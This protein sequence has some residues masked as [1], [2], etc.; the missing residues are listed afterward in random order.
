MAKFDKNKVEPVYSFTPAAIRKMAS[1]DATNLLVKMSG[2]VIQLYATIAYGYNSK[3]EYNLTPNAYPRIMAQP[4]FIQRRPM[5]R[6]ND[7]ELF[8][9]IGDSKWDNFNFCM[10][11]WLYGVDDSLTNNDML[12]LT[13]GRYVDILDSRFVEIT[14]IESERYISDY[15]KIYLSELSRKKID[16][17][18]KRFWR[19]SPYLDY[20]N[21]PGKNFAFSGDI[22]TRQY[23]GVLCFEDD[24]P[25]T[26]WVKLD[27]INVYDDDEQ[28]WRDNPYVPKSDYTSVPEDDDLDNESDATKDSNTENEDTATASSS[29][30]TTL[31]IGAAA[32]LLLGGH[33]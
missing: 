6:A 7:K 33:D 13:T 29:T 12:G 25:K 2:S 8:V 3:E 27:Q 14:P 15:D 22:T 19:L 11:S 32:L 31:L 1:D 30:T 9:S 5:A 24:R 20:P 4:F 18:Y 16:R 28:V 21:A 10:F 17:I 23:D 26:W